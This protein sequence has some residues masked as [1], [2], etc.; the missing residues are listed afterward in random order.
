MGMIT[1]LP[2]GVLPLRRSLP[3]E[4]DDCFDHLCEP[5]VRRPAAFPKPFTVD[6]EFVP[7]DFALLENAHA[8]LLS[9][10]NAVGKDQQFRNTLAIDRVR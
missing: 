5:S 7:P 6:G 8:L 3:G 9:V 2:A 1:C 4:S 10:K